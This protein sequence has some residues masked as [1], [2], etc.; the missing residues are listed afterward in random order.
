[1]TDIAGLLAGRGVEVGDRAGTTEKV[2]R[3]VAAGPDS[4][5]FIV[6][7]DYTLTR[8]HRDGVAVD[9]SWGVLENFTELPAEYHTKVNQVRSKYYPVEIDPGLSIEEKVPVMVEWY[10]EANSLLGLSGVNRSWFPRMV[11]QSNC[12]FRDNTKQLLDG[13]LQADIPVLV[14]SAGL[15]D[16]IE[17]IMRHHGVLHT[18]TKLISNFLQFDQAGQIV[19]LGR[20]EEVIHMFNKSEVIRRKSKEE[21]MS[22]RKNTVLLGDSLGDV[23][24]ADGVESPEVVLKIGFLNKNIEQSLEQYKQNFDL[25]LVDDQTMSVPNSLLAMVNSVKRAHGD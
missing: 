24:M 20:D 5:Q 3:L 6:D 21:Q 10:K 9:C 14:L 11:Q 1:M 23:R 8:A 17:E 13:L 22:H 4:L 7:F 19:G 25:V 15:G 12:E 18:N 16:L 2:Q